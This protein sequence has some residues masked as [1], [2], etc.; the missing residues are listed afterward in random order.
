MNNPPSTAAAGQAPG[1]EAAFPAAEFSARQ[2]K[3]RQTLAAR[4]I[5]ALIVT[6]P[7][8]IFYLTGQQTPGYYT[9]Q[10][11][12]LPVDREPRFVVRQLEALNCRANSFTPH[13]EIYDDGGDPLAL[14]IQVVQQWGGAHVAIDKAGWFLPIRAYEALTAALGTLMDGAGIVE[15]QRR[16]KSPLEL[17]ALEQ[18]AGYA[19]AGMVAGLD[20]VAAGVD[21]NALVAAMLGTAVAAG[22]EYLGMEP[23]VSSGPRTGVPHGTWRRRLLSPGDPVFLELAACHHRYHAVLMRSAWLGQPPDVARRMMDTCLEALEAALAAVRPGNRAADVHAACQ[24]VIDRAGYTEHYKKRSGY[25]VGIAFAP[26]WGEWQVLSLYHNVHVSLVPGM[27]LHI[28]PALRVFG[29]F[30]VGVSETVV[31]TEHGHRVLGATPRELR[32]VS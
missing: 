27:V 12:V 30:T 15:E 7:E 23:L 22:S 8:N 18:A 13:L 28:P 26:D 17:A 2:Q 4:G 21:E 3:T 20:A 14:L 25:S 1:W 31:V 11:L 6:G 32:V 29:E 9:F 10:A 5:D 16:V 24:G 19:A